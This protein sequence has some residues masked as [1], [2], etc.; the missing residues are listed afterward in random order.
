MIARQKNRSKSGVLSKSASG[1]TRHK[2]IKGLPKE[3][4]MRWYPSTLA[5]PGL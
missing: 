1:L 4:M 2:H 5:L 3:P